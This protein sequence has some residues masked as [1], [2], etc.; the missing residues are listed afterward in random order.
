MIIIYVM[1]FIL[2][3]SLAQNLM[4]EADMQTDTVLHSSYKLIIY[5]LTVHDVRLLAQSR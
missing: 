2:V 3:G 4:V 1:S 5:K